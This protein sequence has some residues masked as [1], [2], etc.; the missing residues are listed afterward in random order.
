MKTRRLVSRKAFT[1]L[2]MVLALAVGMVLLIGLYMALDIHL[3]STDAGR[4]QVDQATVARAVLNKFTIDATNHLPVLPNPVSATASTS[5]ATGAS[6]TASTGTSSTSS[7]TS[8]SMGS[9]S[10]TTTNV[11]PFMFN[12]GVQGGTDW[13]SIYPGVVPRSNFQVDTADSSGSNSGITQPTDS[14]LRRIDYWFVYGTPGGLARQEVVMVTNTED[15]D[16]MPPSVA[17]ESAFIIAHEVMAVSFEYFD[18]SNWQTSWDGTVLGQDGATPI[19]PPLA[20]AITISVRGA[21]S[22]TTDVN[23]PSVL[24]TRHVVH[25]QTAVLNPQ[26]APAGTNTT[27]TNLGNGTT[28]GSAGQSQLNMSNGNNNSGGN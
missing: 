17:N 27:N 23:D 6:S 13:C 18:G 8:S 11:G 22:K 14:D 12:L 19:G 9:T 15:L 7:T 3:R 26:T 5:S 16:S 21:D 10:T 4:S 28:S 25:I 2:E 1:L 20:I 24:T